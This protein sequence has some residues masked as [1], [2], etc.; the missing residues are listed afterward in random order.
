MANIDT[1]KPYKV[2]SIRINTRKL[3]DELGLSMKGLARKAN[4]QYNTVYLMLT[5]DASLTAL[6]IKKIAD[7]LGVE[8]EDLYDS[9]EE[10]TDKKISKFG[11]KFYELSVQ[12]EMSK[13]E[14]CRKSPYSSAYI[15][16]MCTDASIC[17]TRKMRKIAESFGLE[18][19]YF[20]DCVDLP[21]GK[22]RVS[23]TV[24]K[25][26][27]VDLSSLVDDEPINISI[28]GY[29]NVMVVTTERCAT[30]IIERMGTT[31]R[32]SYTHDYHEW[33]NAKYIGASDERELR[34]FNIIDFCSTNLRTL[35]INLTHELKC[36]IVE[37]ARFN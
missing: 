27:A 35:K 20:D 29:S 11:V 12:L 1:K 36:K 32:M 7:A 4:L 25:N 6:N 28:S 22:Q 3:M 31:I 9:V 16:R 8:T 23:I 17:D 24:D 13:K 21:L 37:F 5:R 30:V 33:G 15:Y 26:D 14:M 10:E 2:T 19:T 34:E 18:P